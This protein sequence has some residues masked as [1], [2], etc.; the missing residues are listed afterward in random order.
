MKYILFKDGILT[1]R[2]SSEINGDNIPKEAVQVSDE[3]FYLTIN[4]QDG[5]WS[6]VA[7]EIV[8]LPF[9]VISLETTQQAALTRIQSFSDSAVLAMTESPTQVEVDTWPLKMI[10][11]EAILEGGT[12]L[13][14]GAAFLS[15]AKI[16]ADADVQVWAG[17]VRANAVAYATVAGVA[18]YLKNAAKQAV[19]TA[20]TNDEVAAVLEGAEQQATG[21]IAALKKAAAA[22]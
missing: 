12:L 6:L 9:P 10:T 18:E 1:A 13:P 5:I 4:E 14:A 16:T 20:T 2:Y 15:A 8:K 17:K 19:L 22:G 21:A 11:A 3:L 7:G